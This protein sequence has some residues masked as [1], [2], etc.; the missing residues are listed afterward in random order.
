[1]RLTLNYK[2]IDL[3]ER[4]KIVSEICEKYGDKL[5]EANLE[6]LSDYILNSLEKKERKERNILTDNRMSTVNKRE[7]SFEGL[8]DKFETGE[9]G[10][11][12]IMHE[13]KNVILS[14][15]ISITKKDI[16]EIPFLKEL[17]AAIDVLRAIKEKNYIIQ[18]A[19]IDLAQSQYL[20]KNCY[21]KP[22][23][24][25]TFSSHAG[26]RKEWSKWIDFTNPLHIHSLLKYYPKIKTDMWDRLEDDM[27]WVLI[28][29]E[30]LIE[31]YIKKQHPIYYNIII[32]RLDGL[33]NTQI[34]DQLMIDFQ[35]TYSTEYISSLFNKKIPKLI[36]EGAKQD[37]MNWYFT[38]VEKGKYKTCG[39]CGQVKLLDHTYFSLNKSSKDNFY[40]IC[41][42]CRNKKK[43]S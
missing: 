39:R 34:Q 7:T 11:Y 30:D 1:M 28:D 14:P 23:K 31:R 25:N 40:S 21:R 6:S 9:D 18:A 15:A 2:I 16:E 29:L 8:V 17:R 4:Q 35:E 13:D 33:N 36:S 3:A 32:M 20:I 27:R 43:G 22:L 24:F 41:K 37:E 26:V 42:E 19:I 38:F 5:N 12:Q 10:I